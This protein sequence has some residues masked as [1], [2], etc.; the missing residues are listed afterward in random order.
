ME[1]EV[2]FKSGYSYIFYSSIIISL[3]VLGFSLYS[4]S[5]NNLDVSSFLIL[6]FGTCTI[7]LFS[8]RY[9][10]RISIIRGELCIK[11]ILPFNKSIVIDTKE[12]IEVDKH[13][14]YSRRG[15]KK[16]F[17][18]TK[19][20]HFLIQYNISDQSDESLLLEL[21]TLCAENCR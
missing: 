17:L 12:I 2:Y 21:T 9:D 15:Y 18:K 16:L 6:N 5:N 7:S 1:K 20:E 11:Y 3:T 14:D 4:M 10:C 19:S 13:Q 8:L